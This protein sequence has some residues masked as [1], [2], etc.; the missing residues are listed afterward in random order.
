M[1]KTRIWDMYYLCLCKT[2]WKSFLQ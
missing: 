1:T 2:F